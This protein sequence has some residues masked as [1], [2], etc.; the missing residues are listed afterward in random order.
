M[1]ESFSPTVRLR[2]VARTLCRWRDRSG[3]NGDEVVAK[4]RWARSKLSKI[5]NARQNIE[6]ADVIALAVIYGVDEA[7]RDALVETAATATD[8]GWWQSYGELAPFEGFGDYVGLESEAVLVR[9]FEIDLIPGLLQTEEYATAI[10]QAWAPRA[11]DEEIQ[12]RVSLR[13][14]RQARL[15]GDPPLALHA[16]VTE[17][18]LQVPAGA[19]ELRR[20]QL[21][22]VL[23]RA[24]LDHV[25]VQVLPMSC[26]PHP[27][28]GIPFVILSFPID[29]DP[30]V[31]YIEH[32]TGGVYV[33]QGSEVDAY[34]LNFRALQEIALDP[35][36]S[37]ALIRKLISGLPMH[38]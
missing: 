34:I 11:S 6:P 4:L 27:S 2:K 20:R 13:R 21:E 35:E 32:L 1:P 29:A 5:E 24:S 25:S 19:P 10:A 31:A 15:E 8:K 18:A 36:D 28:M 37:A 23:D 26:G 7:E 38:T 33:E 16:I 9:N 12:K 17:T 14:Q 22:H 30:D 3:L